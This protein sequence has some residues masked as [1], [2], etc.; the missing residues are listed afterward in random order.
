WPA[1][2]STGSFSGVTSSSLTLSWQLGVDNPAG[3]KYFAEISTASDFTGTEDVTTGWTSDD[4]INGF[5]GL[6]WS[7]TYYAQVKARNEDSVETRY[8]YLGSTCTTPPVMYVGVSSYVTTSSST[9]Q[10]ISTATLRFFIKKEANTL[11]PNTDRHFWKLNAYFIGTSTPSDIQEVKVWRDNNGN[12]TFEDPGDVLASGVATFSG[13]TATIT[14][15]NAAENDISRHHT[16]FFVVMQVKAIALAR[17]TFGVRVEAGSFLFGNADTAPPETAGDAEWNKGMVVKATDSVNSLPFNT[18]LTEIN[19]NPTTISIASTSI[20]PDYV[21][22][23]QTNVGMLKLDVT[24]NT[25]AAEIEEMYIYQGGEQEDNIANIYVYRDNGDGA[26]QGAGTDYEVAGP[27][28]LGWDGDNGVWS[29]T[30]TFTP[31]TY[32]QQSRMSVRDGFPGTFFIAYDIKQNADSYEM[33]AASVP[34]HNQIVMHDAMDT[35]NAAGFPLN[36]TTTIVYASRAEVTPER[37]STTWYGADSFI[38]Q[39]DFTPTN[40]DHVYYLFDQTADDPSWGNNANAKTISSQDPTDGWELGKATVTATVNGSWYFHYK[41]FTSDNKEGAAETIGPFYYDGTVP[42]FSDYQYSRVDGSY[43]GNTVYTDTSTS[44]I[45]VTLADSDGSGLSISVSSLP[46]EMGRA[47]YGAL[48]SNNGGATWLDFA[49]STMS[50]D[51]TLPPAGSGTSHAYVYSLQ[52][53]EGNLYSG[54]GGSSDDGDILKF[55]GVSWSHVGSGDDYRNTVSFAAYKGKLYAGRYYPDTGGDI[56]VSDDG[57]SWSISSNTLLA[58]SAHLAV[59]NG[60]LYAGL[61]GTDSVTRVI[62]YDGEDGSEWVEVSD[63][64]D[65]EGVSTTLDSIAVY[66]GKLYVG[67]G[68]AKIYEYDGIDWS[69]SFDAGSMYIPC[70]AVYNN[71]LYAGKGYASG[72]ADDGDIYEFDG[73]DWTQVYE[74]SDG[75]YEYMDVLHV[76]NGKLYAGAGIGDNSGAV[77]VYDGTSWHKVYDAGAYNVMS[78]GSLN[79]KL[80]VG[81][82]GGGATSDMGDIIELTPFEVD[83]GAANDSDTSADLTVY[84]SSDAYKKFEFFP[85]TYT[86]QNRVKFFTSNMA[87]LVTSQAYNVLVDSYAP[88]YSSFKHYDQADTEKAYELYLGTSTPKLEIRAQ[89]YSDGNVYASGLSTSATGTPAPWYDN[90]LSYGALITNN[91]GDSW[92]DFVRS[93]IS[94]QPPVYGTCQAVYNFT[95]FQGELYAALGGNCTGRIYKFNGETWSQASGNLASYVR[96]LAVYDGTFYAAASNGGAEPLRL[97]ACESDCG[98]SANWTEVINIPLDYGVWSNMEVYNGKLY[99]GG[100]HPGVNDAEIYVYDG[101]TWSTSTVTT[102]QIVNAF[103]SYNGKLYAGALYNAGGTSAI[104]VYD[105]VT[106]INDMSVP[107]I[108]RHIV[109]LQV[110]NGKLYAATGDGYSAAGIW[111]Y[112]GSSWAEEWVMGADVWRVTSLGVFNGKLYAGTYDDSHI[113]VKNGSSWYKVYSNPNFGTIAGLM[114]FRGKLYAATAKASPYN[115]SILE[116]TPMTITNTA[117][118]DG[119]TG[120]GTM[121][122]NVGD[123]PFEFFPSTYTGNNQVKFFVSDMLGNVAESASYDVLVDSYVPVVSDFKHYDQNDAEQAYGNYLGTSTPKMKILLQ[124]SRSGLSTLTKSTP[125]VRGMGYGALI[126]NN[127]GASW[128]D[129]AASAMSFDGEMQRIA[130]MVKHN[131]FL[132]AGEQYGPGGGQAGVR[133]FDGTTWDTAANG[134]SF[135]SSIGTYK[136]N[137]YVGTL[138]VDAGDGDIYVCNPGANEKCEPGEWTLSFGSPIYGVYSFAEY[139]GRFY[140]GFGATSVAAAA[141]IYEY[142]GSTWTLTYAG[143]SYRYIYALAVYNGKLYAGTGSGDN[144]GDVLVFD[145]SNWS[146]SKDFGDGYGGVYSL[147]VYNGKLYAGLGQSVDDGDVAVY[148]GTTWSFIYPPSEYEEVRSLVVFSGKLYAGMGSGAGDGDILVFDGANWVKAHDSGTKYEEVPS[149][150]VYNGKLYAGMGASATHPPGDNPQNDGDVLEFTPMAMTTTASEADTGAGKE[151]EL[152]LSNTPFEFFPST[153]VGN[154]QVKF[155]A[156]DMVGNVVISASYDVLVDSYVPVVS[157]F[158]VYD[159]SGSA[160]PNP[161]TQYTD[162]STP[163]MTISLTDS[164]SGLSTSTQSSGAVRGAGYG[165][166]FTNNGG[167]SWVDFAASNMS[168]DTAHNS[169]LVRTLETINGNLYAGFGWETGQGRIWRF[170]GTTWSEVLANWG[171]GGEAKVIK[172][173]QGAL[174]AGVGRSATADFGYMYRSGDDGLTWALW[175]D[176]LD[177]TA[178]TLSALKA[179]NNLLYAGTYSVGAGGNVYAYN[180]SSWTMVYDGSADS[181]AGFAVLQSYNGDLYAGAF[182]GGDGHD[183]LKYDY[184]RGSWQIACDFDTNRDSIYSAE[185]YSG[186]LYLGMDGSTDDGDIYAYDGETCSQVYEGGDGSYTAVLDLQV[187][188]GKLYAAMSGTPDILVYDG[189][190]WKLVYRSPGAYTAVSALSVYNREMYI[191]MGD[192]AGM[193]DVFKLTPMTMTTT[194]SEGDT[195]LKEISLDLSD[196]GF[197]FFPSTHVLQN[198]VKFFASDTLG[199]VAITPYFN[200]L[201]DKTGPTVDTFRVCTRAEVLAGDPCTLDG[202]YT[203]TSTPK[204][205]MVITD[206]DGGVSVDPSISGGGQVP[207]LRGNGGI[208]FGVSVS[209]TGGAS[210]LDFMRVSTHGIVGEASVWAFAEHNGQLY[211]AKEATDPE[212]YVNDGTGWSHVATV[213]T[214]DRVRAMASYNGKLYTGDII[215]HIVYEYDG[216]NWSISTQTAANNRV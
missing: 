22:G 46:T 90:P 56:F 85:S 139:N 1:Q 44:K 149:L 168:Y 64:A 197:E 178:G 215:N 19:D 36:S 181:Y 9:Y 2:V 186:K 175:K 75:G 74:G 83:K 112:D 198:Q 188:N 61:G 77:L 69:F 109:D 154:N 160:L 63:D 51:G 8:I 163:K 80:Y 55:D 26:F 141:D 18:H 211:A 49:R 24:A 3:T 135:R 31:S 124:D 151:I 127:G 199:N 122:F 106:W 81:L 79:G 105:G 184:D 45:Q 155:F 95:A 21:Y 131:G 207:S 98:N 150:A 67:V 152:D 7:T 209:N 173:Y 161:Y 17:R 185:V 172:E 34:N 25:G 13:S 84:I 37:S 58:D 96:S 48:I 159:R 134:L 177:E 108:L 16:T 14:M 27:D 35:V 212:I 145:G 33:I 208:G 59:Y 88:V 6:D 68:G 190:N 111:V 200:V 170:N 47:G 54:M 102:A 205:S 60:K 123:T 132:Y 100:Y 193:A 38:F 192:A 144:A 86:T 210:W 179:H 57:T 169:A 89:D 110:Y 140:A 130:S 10:G 120:S 82:G 72:A 148:D 32:L 15:T 194:A 97:F 189:T 196:T 28:T 180:G 171:G 137:L 117:S 174:Y 213:P 216:S 50:H 176:N 103:E 20:T 29:S 183:L 146:V 195:A 191:G 99:A 78:L 118:G 206:A 101:F 138:G 71:K 39:C 143:A 121:V 129:F 133:V 76:F 92:L 116:F 162:T 147:A 42:T 52:E 4:Y 119:D 158:D 114:G 156:S 204:A 182:N 128:L 30:V 164:R 202:V 91:G 41:P 203:G 115:V 167:S 5:T 104:Y 23:D 136:S 142:D 153:Y 201:V 66:N 107:N 87:G 11:D 125:V 93:T 94:Y 73:T 40:V 214:G 157:A 65:F 12:A 70:L 43:V 165:A 113:F 166:L 53:F 62:S 187:F 126:T